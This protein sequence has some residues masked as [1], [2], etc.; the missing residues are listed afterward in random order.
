MDIWIPWPVVRRGLAWR[1]VVC[2]R[3]RRVSHVREL[4][5]R[6]CQ[7]ENFRVPPHMH[8]F[9]SSIQYVCSVS[10]LQRTTM[11]P[12]P[13]YRCF[14]LRCKGERTRTVR[15]IHLHIANDY[16]QSIDETHPVWVRA[17]Y[18]N[19]AEL[20]EDNLSAQIARANGQFCLA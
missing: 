18:R 16:V 20:N 10:N 11:A 19:A 7:R 2:G 5:Q 12:A 13:Q 9:T 15:T 6:T 1:S 17:Q 14:C 3:G 4:E 8:A